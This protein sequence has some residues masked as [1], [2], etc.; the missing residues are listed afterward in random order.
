ML[1]YISEKCSLS[2]KMSESCKIFV[3]FRSSSASNRVD[4]LLMRQSMS[5]YQ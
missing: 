4:Y 1:V 5:H 3:R 2:E